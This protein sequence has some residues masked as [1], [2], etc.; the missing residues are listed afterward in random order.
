MKSVP[1]WISYHH[2]NCWISGPFVAILII[3]LNSK[4]NLEF[5][6]FLLKIHFGCEDIHME[7]VVPF[8]ETLRT[9]FCFKFFELGKVLL[10]SAKV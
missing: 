1:N 7:K 10:G 8:I 4:T 9:I 2:A 3:F 5:S 6:I